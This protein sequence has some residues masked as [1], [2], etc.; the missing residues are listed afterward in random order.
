MKAITYDSHH[1]HAHH[2]TEG[3]LVLLIIASALLLKGP[4]SSLRTKGAFSKPVLAGIVIVLGCSFYILLY[5]SLFDHSLVILVLNDAI[6]I[7]FQI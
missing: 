7:K 5:F 6:K 1:C 4:L 2:T 3:H